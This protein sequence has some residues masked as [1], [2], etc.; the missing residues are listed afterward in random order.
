MGSDTL[1]ESALAAHQALA[2]S[3]VSGVLRRDLTVHSE[4]NDGCSV[5]DPYNPSAG[6]LARCSGG[7]DAAQAVADAR[8]IALLLGHGEQLLEALIEDAHEGEEL[9]SH[10]NVMRGEKAAL[11]DDIAGLKETIAQLEKRHESFVSALEQS[12]KGVAE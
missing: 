5:R 8:A 10:I 7:G 12:L 4:G 1:L 11:E 6:V 2:L 9:E 3:R